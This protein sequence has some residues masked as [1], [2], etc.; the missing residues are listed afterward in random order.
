MGRTRIVYCQRFLGNNFVQPSMEY[1]CTDGVPTFVMLGGEFEFSFDDYQE[2]RWD[3]KSFKDYSVLGGDYFDE[4]DPGKEKEARITRL[5]TNY[6]EYGISWKDSH[7][8]KSGR[9]PLY[10]KLVCIEL[11]SPLKLLQN[12]Y[13]M[14]IFAPNLFW[15][16]NNSFSS[17]FAELKRVL[18]HGGRIITIFPDI[19]Q[20]D[21]LFYRFAADSDVQWINDLDRGIH[22]NLTRHARSLEEWGKYFYQ[23]GLRITRQERFYTITG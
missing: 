12:D 15:I 23:H 17:V 10:N 5:P 7:I 3:K 18:C 21:Y 9:L 14:T 6:F 22:K 4:F 19:S 8:R 1:G 11:G 20:K 2:V 16:E 13:F